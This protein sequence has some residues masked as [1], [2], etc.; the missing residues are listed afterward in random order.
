MLAAPA[1]LR[2]PRKVR[3]AILGL[4]GHIEEILD[5]LPLLPDVELVAVADRDG[6]LLESA[7]RRP[8]AAHARRYADYRESLDRE[9]LDMAGICGTD[10][11]RAAVI[12]A[13]AARKIHVVAENAGY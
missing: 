4:E 3:L 1:P 10:G 13:C 2:L 9:Q 6:K 12:L 5:P 8:A 7:A 11:E